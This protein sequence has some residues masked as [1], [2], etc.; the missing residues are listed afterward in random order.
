MAGLIHFSVRYFKGYLGFM[1]NY[2]SLG[3]GAFRFEEGVRGDYSSG[4]SLFILAYAS[5][6]ALREGFPAIERALESDL[7]AQEIRSGEGLW[8][9]LIDDRGKLLSLQAV[10]NLLLICLEDR[11]AAGNAHGL[12][13]AIRKNR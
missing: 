11:S 8:L 2:P 9:S 6:D 4:A 5:E 1:N 13:E 12:F 7:R 10:R 3:Q